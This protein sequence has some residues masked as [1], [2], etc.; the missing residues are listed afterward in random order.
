MARPIVTIRA[1]A[2]PGDDPLAVVGAFRGEEPVAFA[3]GRCTADGYCL[4]RLDAGGDAEA[5]HALVAHLAAELAGGRFEAA[6]AVPVDDL[7]DAALRAAGLTITADE[8]AYQGPVGITPPPS[9]L[10]FTPYADHGKAAVVDLLAA[11]GAPGARTPLALLDDLLFAARADTSLWSVAA[12]DGV[13]IGM[14]IAQRAPARIAYLGIVPALRGRG[15]GA[16][17]LAHALGT[18]AASGA[19]DHRA[20]VSAADV[21]TRRLLERAGATA[22]A[23]LR[24]YRRPAATEPDRLLALADLRALLEARGHRVASA[25]PDWLALPVRC[26]PHRAVVHLGWARDARLLHVLHRFAPTATVPAVLAPQIAREICAANASLNVAG[27]LYDEATG[28][29]SFRVTLPLDDDGGVTRALL[30][31]AVRA[32]VAA[33][34]THGAALCRRLALDAPA[35]RASLL[36]TVATTSPSSA[37]TPGTR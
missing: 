3:H 27:Y 11:I 18:L 23:T 5:A 36:D 30:D 7:A 13:A 32:V 33:A 25:S 26:G 35:P 8:V 20:I 12:F 4:E 14:A 24:R 29:L 16:H 34:A 15:L 19:R 31:R 10:R 2:E 9:P 21:A 37:P 6:L 17:L 1:P 22:I 28:E